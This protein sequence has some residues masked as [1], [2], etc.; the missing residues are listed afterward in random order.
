M[1]HVDRKDDE[2]SHLVEII[3]ILRFFHWGWFF[4][5]ESEL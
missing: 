3:E 5:E 1:A 2:S 4:K